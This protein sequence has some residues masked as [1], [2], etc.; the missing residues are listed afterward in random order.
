MDVEAE[1]N[2]PCTG[3]PI[4]LCGGA[5]RYT[6]YTWDGTMNVWHKP[7]NVGR[8]EVSLHLHKFDRSNL[9]YS[10]SVSLF[11]SNNVSISADWLACAAFQYLGEN[12][13][14]MTRVTS[15]TLFVVSL[16]H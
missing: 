7:T 16:Y 15:L 6:Y 10:T 12:I 9:L 8:Y 4:H 1:C 5:N 2:I 11:E 3:D 13:I 14:Y